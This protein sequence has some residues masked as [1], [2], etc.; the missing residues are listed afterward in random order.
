MKVPD[1][2]RRAI[3]AQLHRAQR[4]HS[5]CADLLNNPE[6]KRAESLEDALNELQ[7]ASYAA[8]SAFRVTE[9]RRRGW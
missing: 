1:E 5:D 4:A 2:M 9:A 3:W 6:G 8:R 7:D